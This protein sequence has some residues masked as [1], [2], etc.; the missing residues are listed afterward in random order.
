MD[1]RL[2]VTTVQSSIKQDLDRQLQRQSMWLRDSWLWL[3]ER[4][5]LGDSRYSERRPTALDVGCGPGIVMQLLERRIDLQ[6][7]DIDSGMVD[8]CLSKGLRVEK[9]AAE[10]LP[11]EDGSFDVAYC[12][13]LLLWVKDPVK[14]ISE[15]KRVSRHWIICLAEPDFGGRIDH[16]E[17]VSALSKMVSDGIR[18]DGGDP[19]VGRKLRSVYSQCGLD[20][21]LGVHPGIWSLDKLRLESEDEWR[22]IEMT[23]APENRGPEIERIRRAWSAGLKDGSLFQFNPIFYAF[24]EKAGPPHHI[25]E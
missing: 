2:G 6:G 21:E 22:Y 13:F 9:A 25:D 5:V 24:A 19:F 23:I 4:K 17:G 3:L 18:H 10:A 12:S 1:E 7:I 15:M 16:P 8:D 20:P 14:V 11:F